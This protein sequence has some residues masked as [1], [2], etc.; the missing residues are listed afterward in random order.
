VD[1]SEDGYGYLIYQLK[2]QTQ[3]D[4]RDNRAILKYASQAWPAAL[5]HRPPYYQEGFAF[6]EGACDSKY[7][8]VASPFPLHMKTD[9]KPLKWLKTCVKGPLNQWRVAKITDLDYDIEHRDGVLNDDADTVSRHP[10]LGARSLVRV[11]TDVAMKEI[12]KTLP[13]QT[14]N[15][16]KWWVWAGR[17][18][19]TMTKI[20]QEY[21][22]GRGKVYARAPKESFNNPAWD[23]AIVMPR[24][25][26]ATE[27]CRLAIDSGRKICVLMPT[28]LVYYTAQEDDRSFNGTY[29]D[30]IKKAKKL[31]LMAT[32][33]TWLCFNTDIPANDVRSGETLTQ[34]P[35]PSAGWTP[36][37]GTLEEW[38]KEQGPSIANET[39]LD[40]AK[41]RSDDC[42]L[43]MYEGGDGI[44][45]IY[46]PLERRNALIKLHHESIR[47]LA[48]N[49]TYISLHRHFYWPTA[50]QDVRKYYST[51]TFCELS[52]ATRNI[53]HKRS[54]AVQS[55]PP[56]SR[57]G[58]D[59]YGV[60][61][62][63]VLGI[64]DLDSVNV[65]LFWHERRSGQ[66]VKE[67]LRDGI[68]NRYGR[69]DELRSDHAREFIGRAVSALK[70]EVGFF[71]S[72]TGGH[73]AKGNSTMERFWRFLGNCLSSLT[74]AQYANAKDHIQA[75]AFAWNSTISE[76]LNVSPFEVHTGTQPRTIADGFLVQS[77][78]ASDIQISGIVTAAAEFARIARANA[79][80]N[81]QL[82]A[83]LLNR[84][85]RKL[86][87]LKI[88]DH[89]KIFAPPGH[90]EAVER[91]RKQKHMHSWKGP[92]R[93]TDKISGTLFALANEYNDKQTYNRHLVN[94]RRW[95]GPVPKTAPTIIAPHA[96]G[97]IEVGSIVAVQDEPTSTKLDIARVTSITDET[98]TVA[99]YGTRSKVLR[100][101]KLY[102]VY[103]EGSDV[104]LG[105]PARRKKAMPWTWQIQ[106]EDVNELIPAQGLVFKSSG[107]LNASS[108]KV[109]ES[110]RPRASVRT[111]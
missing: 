111:F 79:D 80:F 5:R 83:D 82:S 20:V 74:D 61:D 56:R 99:C 29:I 98:V 10:M 43:K 6:V 23:I 13:E 103:T 70:K 81:R 64:I 59:Y 25:E 26:N 40:P 51:C 92:M 105:K 108:V 107:Q 21:K 91:R 38:A 62:G 34:P 12:L 60:G 109:I 71:Q 37:V 14:A 35:G 100:K 19:A 33:C 106:T 48:A 76:S 55:R 22:V 46:V 52:K 96:S 84:E 3:P 45:R 15:T 87:D 54:R 2:D 44:T 18:T 50:R 110:I 47:H 8:A 28:E 69:F 11:G 27:V 75:I 63:E 49:K 36:E 67:A 42:G 17:D 58:M 66:L 7:Y 72:T 95:L 97:D 90:K 102:E 1:A 65:N 73:N 24:T 94:I 89:V 9:H 4:V 57:Y 41:I 30:A 93:I 68:M 16:D 88:G 78:P 32:D 101:A 104:F 53:S 39:K 31:T 86:R 77:E 85:G